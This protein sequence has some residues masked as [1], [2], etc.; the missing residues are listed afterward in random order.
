MKIRLKNFHNP[1]PNSARAICSAYGQS[2]I[3]QKQVMHYLLQHRQLRFLER[4]A[5]GQLFGV[6]HNEELVVTEATGPY[7]TDERSR[8][9][10]RSDPKEAQRAID[11]R[12]ARNLLYLGE[13]HTHPEDEPRMSAADA[14]A[15]RTL[16]ERSRLN[17]REVLLL[18]VGRRAPPAGLALFTITA[19]D[20]VPWT[21]D[22]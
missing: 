15:I 14:S 18:I 9:H 2:V 1:M 4:E 12:F 8:T 10:Y 22:L 13:W 17:L 21:F 16:H 11:E 5:G 20:V 19:D 6:L 3:L 7:A